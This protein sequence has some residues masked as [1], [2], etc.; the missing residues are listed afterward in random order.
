MLKKFISIAVIVCGGFCFLSAEVRLPAIL[1]DHMVL[2]RNSTVRLWG[3]SAPSEQFTIQTS[4]D[5]HTYEV[6]ADRNAK[7]E[8]S[9]ATPDAG[10]PFEIKISASNTITLSDILIGEVWICSGQSNM[11]W[12]SVNG[13][14]RAEEEVVDANYPKIRFFQIPKTTSSY[15]QENVNANWEICTPEA[16]RDFSAVAYFFGRTLQEELNIPIGLIQAAWGGTAAETWTPRSVIEEEPLFGKWDEVL[17]KTDWWPRDPGVTFNA[18]I[19]PVSNFRIAGAIWYQGESNT[20]NP[21]VYRKLFP[22]MI[23]SWRT[24]WGYPFPFYYVQIA[25]FRYG[26]PFSGALV[27]EA[28]M[29]SMKV[30][31]TGMVVVSD[32]GNIND[33]HPGNKQDV[34]KRLA[35]WALARTYGKQGFYPSGPIYKD[36]QVEGSQIRIHFDF[37]D[38]GLITLEG[39][40][41]HF[42]IAGEDRFFFPAEAE[43]DGS[44]V[45]VSSDI[46]PR[47]VAVRYA[48]RN[49]ADPN[50]FNAH[51]LPASS[52]R[53]DDWPILAREV[54][55]DINYQL[56]ADAYLVSLNADDDVESIKYSTNGLSPGLFGL[57]YT[58]PFYIDSNCVIKAVAATAEGI[59]DLISEKVV[60]LNK[61]TFKNIRYHEA[62]HE[63]MNAGGEQALVDGEFGSEVLNDGRWQGFLG[64]NM[65]VIIDMGERVPINRI[66]VNALKNQAARAFLP[67]KVT[68]EISNDGDRFVEVYREPIFHA[69]EDG[70][71]IRSYDFNLRNERKTRFIR[72]SAENMKVCPPWHSRAGDPTWMVFDEIVIE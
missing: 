35:N 44:S 27:R 7:W 26:T 13:F 45:L 59:S 19:Y 49:T 15:P 9:I 34:G 24:A 47:P 36:Y 46:V 5:N 6:K 1:A 53:T 64:N 51:N 2:Q 41:S 72:I 62:Y 43:I 11:E 60:N 12:S 3:W 54:N 56:A 10:G 61:A 69:R 4:W 38:D 67:N 55:F 17:S 39:E 16:F 33:I 57:D 71:E 37:A 28:Q 29:H 48:F 32:I 63:N 21:L 40:P 52:F 68:Y 20:A 18:M 8:T 50:L 31:N 70:V 66:Q 42:E 30:L 65:E 14:D 22:A 58:Q 23:Q 25:P